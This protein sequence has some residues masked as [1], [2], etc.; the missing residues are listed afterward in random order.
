MGTG[1]VNQEGSE[2]QCQEMV[3]CEALDGA[4]PEA[5]AL[6]PACWVMS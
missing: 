2:Q 1:N 6:A 5:E 4:A 3:Q